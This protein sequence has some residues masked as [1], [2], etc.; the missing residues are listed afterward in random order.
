MPVLYSLLTTG[1]SRV[2][3]S[4]AFYRTKVYKMAS[5]RDVDHIMAIFTL[6]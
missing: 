4:T 5:L 3:R 6:F 1:P 2:L